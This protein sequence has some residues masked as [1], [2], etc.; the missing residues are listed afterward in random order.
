[1]RLL[2]S[3]YGPSLKAK[4]DCRLDKELKRERE[5]DKELKDEKEEATNGLVAV[6]MGGK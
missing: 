2:L 1:M 3:A 5:K 6:D 4:A